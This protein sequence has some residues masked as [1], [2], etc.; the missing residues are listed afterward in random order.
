L[1][2]YGALGKTNI[3]VEKSGGSPRFSVSTNA[4]CS[5]AERY[6]VIDSY[7][8]AFQNDFVSGW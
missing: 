3:D 2:I 8:E 7:M 4:G 1:Y 5:T 6:M